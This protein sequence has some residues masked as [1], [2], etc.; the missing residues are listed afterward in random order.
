MTIIDCIL[1]ILLIISNFL[2]L[3]FIIINKKSINKEENGGSIKELNKHVE[4]LEYQIESDKSYI[5]RL[6]KHYWCWYKD[7][8]EAVIKDENMIVSDNFREENKR[9]IKELNIPIRW[10]EERFYYDNGFIDK[11]QCK[12][13]FK[14]YEEGV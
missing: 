6:E 14:N 7:V 10:Y 2:Y 13:L 3:I 4:I 8:L 11:E 12:Y 1:L 5:D 9:I